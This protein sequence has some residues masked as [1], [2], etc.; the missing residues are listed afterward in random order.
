[1]EARGESTQTEQPGVCL[2]PLARFIEMLTYKSALDGIQLV[3]IDERR[4]IKHSFLDLEPIGHH[5]RY[6]GK[7]VKWDSFVASSGQ[8]IHTDVNGAYNILRRYASH[9]TAHGVE[10][11]FLRPILLRLPDRCQDR[12][13]QRPRRKAE[14]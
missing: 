5:D 14:A 12:S 13:K 7:R 1:V 3:T 9:V 11:L 2:Y 6:L 10:V 8:V 4:T